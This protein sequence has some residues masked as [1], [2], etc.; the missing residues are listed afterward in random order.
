M[1]EGFSLTKFIVLFL[2][3]VLFLAAV[4]FLWQGLGKKEKDTAVDAP[5]SSSDMADY[6]ED[7]EFVSENSR[8]SVDEILAQFQEEEPVQEQEEVVEDTGLHRSDWQLILVNKQHVIPEDY[9]FELGSINT[10]KGTMKCD[11][12]VIADLV[13]MLSAA[14]RSGVDLQICSPYRSHVRQTSLF[15]IKIKS[16]LKQG[17]SY[18]ESYA[19]ASQAVTIPGSSEHEI[20]LA[21]DIVATD[22]TYLNE[23]FG[24][25]KAGKWLAKNCANYGF[26]LRYPKG[27]EEITGIEYE[28]W[29]FRYVGKKAAKQITEHGLTLEEFVDTLAP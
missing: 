27:K 5:V 19:E 22:Y 18:L 16:G 21:F 29:H 17:K 24:D 10:M 15:N 4:S 6:N 9:E 12:R 3:F 23:G 8:A 2:V 14:K 13:R 11:R 1:K 20:G 26:I 28:P 25:T 7:L